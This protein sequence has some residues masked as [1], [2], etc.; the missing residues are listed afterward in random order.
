MLFHSVPELVICF[1]KQHDKAQLKFQVETKIS[2]KPLLVSLLQI[3]EVKH[4][5]TVPVSECQGDHMHHVFFYN[6][7][8]SK[9]LILNSFSFVKY[10]LH[11]N[12][13]Y[14]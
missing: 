5:Y 6:K 7:P 11:Y 8:D 2:F 13:L 4:I 10:T 3:V 12:L 1:I 14:I 9:G